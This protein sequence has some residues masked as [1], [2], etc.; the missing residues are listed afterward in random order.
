VLHAKAAPEVAFLVAAAAAEAPQ[1]RSDALIGLLQQLEARDR[2]RREAAA[3]G[4][5]LPA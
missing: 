1:G 4:L 2:T 5:D 3:P